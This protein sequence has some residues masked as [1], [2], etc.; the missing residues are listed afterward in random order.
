MIPAAGGFAV[1]AVWSEHPAGK[2]WS[3]PKAVLRRVS[4]SCVVGASCCV[5]GA[6]RAVEVVDRVVV[7]PLVVEIALSFG[8][9]LGYDASRVT[10]NGRTPLPS[11]S[12]SSTGG[13]WADQIS[14]QSVTRCLRS[15]SAGR[16]ASYG[17]GRSDGDDPVPRHNS[18]LACRVWCPTRH[19]SGVTT[20][21]RTDP[22]AA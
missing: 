2:T 13:V 7:R 14:K 18:R 20:P 8:Y 11:W 1:R 4:T 22:E 6:V 9:L 12:D 17:L 5:V 19:L 15:S 10:P 3:N 21:V 16:P